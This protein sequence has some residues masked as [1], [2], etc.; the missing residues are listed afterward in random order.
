[1]SSV[2]TN[3]DR[4]PARK[5]ARPTLGQ[6]IVL[7][8]IRV[9]SHEQHDDGL[10]I[11]QQLRDAQRYCGRQSDWIAGEVFQDVLSGRKDDRPGYRALLLAV[12]GHVL[13][14]RRV[15]VVVQRLDRLGRNM[16]ERVDVWERLDA[17]GAELH[18][19]AEGR[20]ARFVY[21]IYAAAADEES[22]LIGDRITRVW[23]GL[24]EKGWH[25]PGRVAW[26]FDT[27]PRTDTEQADGAPKA[28]LVQHAAHAAYARE[29][30]RRYAD[31]ES[32]EGLIRWAA[33]LPE[34]AKG[35]RR[36]N[37]SAIREMLRLPVYIGRLGGAH[38]I[39]ACVEA[40]D[41]CDVLDEPR[42]RWEPLVDDAT[43]L[44]AHARYR[45]Q[46]RLPAQASGG[47]LLSGLIRC[48]ACGFRMVGNPGNRKRA[49]RDRYRGDPAD[50]RRYICSSRMHG[51]PEQR[52]APCYAT[53]NA[54]GIER[55]VI[56]TLAAMLDRVA[57]RAYQPR[58]RAAYRAQVAEHARDDGAREVA[59]L[60]GDLAVAERALADA[61]LALFGQ[62]I[63][64]KAYDVTA[65]HLTGEIERL[66]GERARRRGEV[67][68]A[69]PVPI[70]PLVVQVAG[71]APS[72]RGATV[73]AQRPVLAELI[74]WVRP[75][76]VGR[77]RY[78]VSWDLTVLG[79]ACLG[80]A[81]AADPTPTLV[82]VE[83]FGTTNYWTATTPPALAS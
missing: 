29:L 66:E 53:V 19:D 22:R 25:R 62:R 54:A 60:A 64:Q 57:D 52:A 78:E 11:P 55:M 80:Y 18:S 33:G 50:L 65:R 23:D 73:A 76:R 7:I 83:R 27:R 14:G 12:E 58:L 2:P 68:R 42:A 38:D 59:R 3:D 5:R 74:A 81:V 31:G 77:G 69:A 70:D 56:D 48:H 45:R 61:S 44:A 63:G 51:T 43:W 39:A 6:I 46:R 26:G 40:G 34:A 17:L 10:S 37:G 82:A 47:Y 49:E 71:W 24:K 9:S 72:L 35:R 30:W 20:P 15:V 32:C 8:Y 21:N 16:K 1:M 67:R 75:V 79:K 28:V 36:L 13:A 4:P 41:G